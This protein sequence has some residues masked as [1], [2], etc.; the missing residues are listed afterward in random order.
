MF[1]AKVDR[2]FEREERRQ[3]DG[4][5]QRGSPHRQH[6]WGA[7][8][9]RNIRPEHHPSSVPTPPVVIESNGVN[10]WM[11]SCYSSDPLISTETAAIPVISEVAGRPGLVRMQRKAL[12]EKADGSPPLNRSVS[13]S[14]NSSNNNNSAGSVMR[15]RRE[16][17]AKAAYPLTGSFAPSPLV[18]AALNSP[19]KSRPQLIRKRSL[20]LEKMNSPCSVFSDPVQDWNQAAQD[21]ADQVDLNVK[22]L[23]G[24]FETPMRLERPRGWSESSL[25][26]TTRSKQSQRR[27]LACGGVGKPPTIPDGLKERKQPITTNNRHHPKLAQQQPVYG[28]M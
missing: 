23:V 19:P 11:P 26:G 9:S 12:L 4:S 24:L 21:A 3:S 18:V 1:S 14:G 5:I 13:D 2:V 22:L 16:L 25:S 8:E 27:S 15:L 10:C 28:T 6:S 7:G 17:E 20:S